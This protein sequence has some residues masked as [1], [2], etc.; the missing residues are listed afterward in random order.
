MPINNNNPINPNV[1]N[2]D[3]SSSVD[4]TTNQTSTTQSSLPKATIPSSASRASGLA[5]QDALLGAS[6]AKFQLGVS[7]NATGST[8]SGTTGVPPS[9]NPR[10]AFQ[11]NLNSFMANIFNVPNNR[12]RNNL[13]SLT[14]N[15]ADQLQNGQMVFKGGGTANLFLGF[16]P[17]NPFPPTT[18]AQ[19][20]RLVLDPAA[21][22]SF[23]NN[24]NQ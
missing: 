9:L 14:V 19:I 7:L 20:P 13:T 24:A 15:S 16:P 10:G 3:S 5:A 1:S 12:F 18:T 23:S 22:L 2:V 17:S 4:Q 21:V 6:F 8:S 11:N